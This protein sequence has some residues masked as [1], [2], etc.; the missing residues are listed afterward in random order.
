M[1]KRCE[2]DAQYKWHIEDIISNEEEYEKIYTEVKMLLD[3]IDNMQD[4]IVSNA[5]NL[6]K[7]LETSM[8]CDYFA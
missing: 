4:M 7:Y 8:R 1:V 3:K 2:I 5:K 6:Q